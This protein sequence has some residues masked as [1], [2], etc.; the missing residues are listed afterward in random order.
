MGRRGGSLRVFLRSL[1]FVSFIGFL[2]VEIQASEGSKTTTTTTVTSP[3]GNF[4]QLE[5]IGTDSQVVHPDL[6]INYM[7][8]RRVPNGPD[9]IH[10]RRAGKSKQ[11]PGRA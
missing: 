6:D 3:A 2:L 11:P 9:P 7:S 1:A 4:K 5:V 10:N 8:K